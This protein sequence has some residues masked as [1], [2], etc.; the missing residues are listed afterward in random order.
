MS[1]LLVPQLEPFEALPTWLEEGDDSVLA[2]LHEN[3]ALV[4]PSDPKL[5]AASRARRLT[6]TE[7]KQARSLMASYLLRATRTNA[8]KHYSQRRPMTHLFQSPDQEWTAD[9]SGYV[10]GAFAWAERFTKFTV[11]DPNGLGYTGWGFTGTLLSHNFRHQVPEGRTY[12]VGDIA[13]YGPASRTKHTV[14]CRKGGNAS[15][16]VWS[17][18]GSE[19]GP[20]DVR[21]HYRP[22]Y[23][24]VVRA[25]SLL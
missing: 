9:C 3:V 23:L 5:L 16:S 8:S 7:K 1:N 20:Y 22:D 18:H 2:A 4:P 15:T 14:I 17:S 11:E 19:A 10:T 25:W 6:P 21:L 24:C 13:L 12:F